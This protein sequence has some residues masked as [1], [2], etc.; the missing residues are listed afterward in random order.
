MLNAQS[1]SNMN[2][3]IGLSLPL[4]PL[5]IFYHPREKLTNF[6]RNK[7]YMARNIIVNKTSRKEG[8]KQE[9]L[10]VVKNFIF[11]IFSIHDIKLSNRYNICLIRKLCLIRNSK[12]LSTR[13]VYFLAN[14]GSPPK[15]TIDCSICIKTLKN[16]G[17]FEKKKRNK[18]HSSTTADNTLMVVAHLEEN[19]YTSIRAVAETGLSKSSVH[20]MCKNRTTSNDFD[21]DKCYLGHDSEQH[22]K[23]FSRQSDTLR[24]AN[25]SGTV[26]FEPC[27]LRKNFRSKLQEYA[28]KNGFPF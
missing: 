5:F 11:C 20:K 8:T 9:S 14:S 12:D 28:I 26:T 17:E 27:N 10:K 7:K 6:G 2:R 16:F 18:P 4:I 23:G 24:N 13:I 22:S 19:P 3:L 25:V 21:L 1:A 15:N